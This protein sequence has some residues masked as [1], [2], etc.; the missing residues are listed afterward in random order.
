M[1]LSSKKHVS[2]N[3]STGEIDLVRLEVQ[4]TSRGWR[5]PRHNEWYIGKDTRWV[6][7]PKG[8]DKI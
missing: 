4:C 2:E 3:G 6:E 8:W 1:N 7:W 5:L